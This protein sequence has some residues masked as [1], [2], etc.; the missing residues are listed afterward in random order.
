ML[1][2]DTQYTNIDTV[3]AGCSLSAPNNILD[4]RHCLSGRGAN[5]GHM[6]STNLELPLA[7]S[8]AGIAP[9]LNSVLG[10]A[11]HI[12]AVKWVSEERKSLKPR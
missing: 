9:G 11:F 12:G 3:E 6:A 5:V 1:Y 4:P 10:N 2:L 7:H 8:V